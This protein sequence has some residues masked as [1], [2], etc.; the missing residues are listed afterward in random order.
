M[1]FH[2][3]KDLDVKDKTVFVRVDF[4]VPMK[5][6]KITDDTRLRA[7]IPTLKALSAAGAKVVIGC[8]LG[9]PDGADKRLSLKPVA[10]A[11]SGLLDMPVKFVDDITGNVVDSAKASL[12]SGELLLLENL[13]FKKAEKAGEQTFSKE[14]AKGIDVYINDAFANSHRTHASMAGMVPHVK[15]NGIGLLM[16]KELETLGDMLGTPKKPFT[17]IIG[18]SKISTKIGVL[19]A[20]IKKAD[21]LAIGGAMANTF[22]AA[23]GMQVGNSLY[24][25]DYLDQA[26][27]ILAEAGILGCRFLLPTDVT[28]ATKIEECTPSHNV[29]SGDVQPHEMILDIGPKT[30]INWAKVIDMSGSVLWNGP[31][32]AFETYPFDEGSKALAESIA[33]SAAFSVVGGGD[34]LACI[35]L[36]GREKKIGYLSTGGG[37]LLEFIENDCTLP[38]LSALTSKTLKLKIGA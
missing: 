5:D 13:R 11:L 8:H 35:A 2:T 9:R 38:A 36:T 34:T 14:L 31:V 7:H 12:A 20:L 33:H 21:T 19:Q 30:A 18:G 15:R 3:L 26:R 6:G 4:N 16:Q 22:F 32:G 23:K 37:A 1:N 29:N 28:V 25:E 17:V 27:D 10:A 24:E